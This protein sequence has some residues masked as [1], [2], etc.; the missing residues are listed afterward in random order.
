MSREITE[1]LEIIEGFI[2]AINVMPIFWE[3]FVGEKLADRAKR[4]IAKHDPNSMY[5]YDL[6]EED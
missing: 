3:E 2:K 5:R 4:F 6:E 1:A